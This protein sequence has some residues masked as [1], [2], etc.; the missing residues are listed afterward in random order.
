M[1]E[2]SF[3]GLRTCQMDRQPVMLLRQNGGDSYLPIV[4][5]PYEAQAISLGWQK[6]ATPRPMSHDLM[7]SLL[8]HLGAQVTSIYINDFKD[9]IFY[10]RL[11]MDANGR[12]AEVDSRPSDAVALAVRTGAPILVEEWIVDTAGFTSEEADVDKALGR[13]GEEEPQKRE[14]LEVF[15]DF[16]NTLDLDDLGHKR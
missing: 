2:M 1:I 16:I 6:V 10:A 14:D 8:A 9:G 5:G 3:N 4:I 13:V 12:H 11:I 7:R 15:R